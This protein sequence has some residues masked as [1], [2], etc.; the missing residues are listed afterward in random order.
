IARAVAGL[1]SRPVMEALVDAA[2]GKE[3]EVAEAAPETLCTMWQRDRVVGEDLL[4]R[5]HPSDGA[6]IRALGV[7][8]RSPW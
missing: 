7:R 1:R 4:L 5:L 8:I 6:R 3:P 2:T